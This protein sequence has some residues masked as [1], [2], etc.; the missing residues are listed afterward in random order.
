MSKTKA[1]GERAHSGPGAAPRNGRLS[2]RGRVVS[3][4][5]PTDVKITP[6]YAL[7]GYRGSC[8]LNRH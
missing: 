6:H 2:Q 8:R 7:S 1:E 5:S 4:R 3:D